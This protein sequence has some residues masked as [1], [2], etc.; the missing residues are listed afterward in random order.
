MKKSLFELTIEEFTRV[1]CDCP[2]TY[3]VKAIWLENKKD[4]QINECEDLGKAIFRCYDNSNN[5]KYSDIDYENDDVD[6]IYATY[7][8]LCRLFATFNDKRLLQYVESNLFDYDVHIDD[9]E[10]Y[11]YLDEKTNHFEDNRVRIVIN[12]MECIHDLDI[13][14]ERLQIIN[15]RIKNGWDGYKMRKDK[16]WDDENK[17]FVED[18]DKDEIDYKDAYEKFFGAGYDFIYT[19]TIAM[20]NEKLKGSSLNK[21]GYTTGADKEDCRENDMKTTGT[22]NQIKNH[23]ALPVQ[24][25]TDEA[26]ALLDKVVKNG[27]C[28]DKYDWK[29]SKILLAYFASKASDTL[30]LSNRMAGERKAVS[31]KPFESLFTIKGKAINHL[32]QAY[33]DLQSMGKVEGQEDI[34]RLF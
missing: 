6:C 16:R 27:F 15:D 12:T 9:L 25:S 31:W 26:K 32:A 1:I 33:R 19:M 21:E 13:G 2:K 7:D 30:E 11:N 34:D 23:D 10:L 4:I 29:R 14:K 24:F 28:D 5:N 20:L 17:R 3:C 8:G 18:D 22:L